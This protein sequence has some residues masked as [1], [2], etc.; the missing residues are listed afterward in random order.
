MFGCGLRQRIADVLLFSSVCYLV[1]FSWAPI[2]FPFDIVTALSVLALA[3]T[4]GDYKHRWWP[5]APYAEK[6]N[7]IVLPVQDR[8]PRPEHDSSSPI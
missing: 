8:V 7:E 4:I 6:E 5:V 3:G 1:V 2:W